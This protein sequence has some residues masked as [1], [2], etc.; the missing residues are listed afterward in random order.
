[1]TNF[2]DAG[3]FRDKFGNSS[4]S[5][6]AFQQVDLSITVPTN[7]SQVP[8]DYIYVVFPEFHGFNENREDK[9]LSGVYLISEVKTVMI[10]GGKSVTYLRINRDSFNESVDVRSEFNLQ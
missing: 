9:Y 6:L 1:M 2:F 7:L 5:F 3:T 4:R 8:G 10:N